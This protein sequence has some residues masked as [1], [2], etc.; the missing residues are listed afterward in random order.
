MKKEQFLLELEE[1]FL[2]IVSDLNYELY[3]IEYVKENNDY[4]LKTAAIRRCQYGSPKR[5]S[6]KTET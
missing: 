4:M 3:H 5:K 2:P 1:M 6:I